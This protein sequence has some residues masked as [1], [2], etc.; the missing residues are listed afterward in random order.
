M[1]AASSVHAAGLKAAIAFSEAMV[2]YSIES[3]E[4]TEP[5]WKD[6]CEK[7]SSPDGAVEYGASVLQGLEQEDSSQGEIVG[8]PDISADA[9]T[10]GTAILNWLCG[11]VKMPEPF[12][13]AGRTEAYRELL[14]WSTQVTQDG[15]SR[16]CASMTLSTSEIGRVV[17]IGKAVGLGE[18]AAGAVV[19]QV[20]SEYCG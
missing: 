1:N 14:L 17:E 19:Q 4:L 16:G 15:A 13:L 3:G 8:L 5:G 6:G 7:F 11:S 2:S 12:S 18:Q 9:E 10:V 20:V